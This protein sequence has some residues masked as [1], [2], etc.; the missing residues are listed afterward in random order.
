[1][2]VLGPCDGIAHATRLANVDELLEGASAAA[3]SGALA[4]ALAL[5]FF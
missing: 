4:S 2:H 3:F 5:Q 1:M